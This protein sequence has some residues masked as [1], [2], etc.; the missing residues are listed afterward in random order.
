MAIGALGRHSGTTLIR[1]RAT[2]QHGLSDIHPRRPERTPIEDGKKAGERE[3]WQVSYINKSRASQAAN[4]PK[5][6]FF[7][8]SFFG[9]VPR[10]G[11][12]VFSGEICTRPA[13]PFATDPEL[14]DWGYRV[15]KT[16]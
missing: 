5:I 6:L 12:P 16:K 9:S 15:C 3:C 1:Q 4:C 10:S 8:N 14:S 7:P 11:N 13:K 2:Y